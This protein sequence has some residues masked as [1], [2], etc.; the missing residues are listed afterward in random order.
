MADF[1]SV[2]RLLFASAKYLRD[3]LTSAT[4]GV[5]VPRESLAMVRRQDPQREQIA[6]GR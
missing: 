3:R 4:H 6:E 1:A 2:A 5:M